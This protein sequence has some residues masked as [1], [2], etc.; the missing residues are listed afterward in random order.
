MRYKSNLL[1]KAIL[2]K[3]IDKVK[4]LISNNYTYKEKDFVISPKCLAMFWDSKIYTLFQK[5]DVS[6]RVFKIE[7]EGKEFL[8]NTNEL[9]DYMQIK[10]IDVLKF[11][12]FY[13]LK[14]M[15]SYFKKKKISKLSKWLGY[16]HE[17]QINKFSYINKFL[18]IKW[19]DHKIEFGIF[20]EK[21]IQANCYIGEYTGLLKK[22]NADDNAYCFEYL[23]YRFFSSVVIDALE[24]GNI[25]RCINHQKNGNLTPFLAYL[26]G[27]EHII[28]KTNR[29]I[30]KNEQLTYDYGMAYWNKREKPIDFYT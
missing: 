27:I 22:S 29:L 17:R 26:N 18:K 25:V 15:F 7:K 6:K 24:E 2:E 16:L 8:L 12:N 20:T 3:N 21:D 23:P 28:L 30:K 19:I 14:K 9:E 10:Y 4:Y 11:D 5:E 13:L 1:Y